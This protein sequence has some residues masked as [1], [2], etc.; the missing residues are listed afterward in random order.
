VAALRS[1]HAAAPIRICDLGG[2][3]DTRVA[4]YGAVLNIAVRPAVEIAIHAFS[5][6]RGESPIVID[7]VNYRLRYAPDLDAAAWGPHPL[8]EAALRTRRPPA[9]LDIEVTVK[10]EAPPGAS[11][12]TSAAVLVALL[13]ALDRLAGGSQLAAAIAQEAHTIET[14]VLG[15][16]SGV[17]DQ[18]CAAHGGIN[19]IEIADYPRSRVQPVSLDAATLEALSRRLILVYLGRPHESSVV[20]ER[21]LA[22]LQRVG[23][24]CAALTNLRRAAVRGRDAL[25]SGDLE[26]FG[27]AMRQNTE[28]QAQLHPSLVDSDARRV[29][30]LAAAHGAVGWKI[31]GAGGDGGS[32]TI[33]AGEDASATAA[34]LR[35][36]GQSCPHAVSLPIELSPDG[37]RTWWRD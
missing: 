19:F 27:G 5:R 8:L 14:A 21:V 16:E 28:A 33:L 15:R 2:W 23:P 7:A 9:D 35:H 1:V 37:L 10:S 20:H 34:F 36:L 29:I 12:G 4:R 22:D 6:G 18:L 30:D 13:G 31:N 25:L 26:A 32:L 11:T 3:T 24:E 17:Q